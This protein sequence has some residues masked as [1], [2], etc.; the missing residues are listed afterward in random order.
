MFWSMR[1]ADWIT[2]GGLVASASLVGYAAYDYQKYSGRVDG[3]WSKEPVEQ[4]QNAGRF[5]KTFPMGNKAWTK[6][7]K[8]QMTLDE[9]EWNLRN[10][11]EMYE[12]YMRENERKS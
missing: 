3:T 9:M 1:T 7:A 6:E 11:Q 5:S 8:K 4:P 2:I 12:Q 10:K